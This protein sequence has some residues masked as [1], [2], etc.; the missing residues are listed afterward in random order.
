[1][2]ALLLLAALTGTAHADIKPVQS[3][4]LYAGV[5][6]TAKLAT[7]S[8]TAA[9]ILS[10]AASL[11]KVSAGAAVS[12]GGL[13]GVGT[14]SPGT[15]LHM[16]SGTLT[17]DGNVAQKA[18]FRGASTADQYVTFGH[19]DASIVGYDLGG[20]LAVGSTAGDLV[21]RDNGGIS[22]SADGGSA[23]N[24]RIDGAITTGGALCINASKNLAKCTSAVDASGNCTCP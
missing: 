21:I 16:S 14:Q 17:V 20:D 6:D 1:M 11:N 13:I 5:V 10:D 3:H 19:D 23:T 8:V 22:F 4:G 24:L 2:K 12:V 15:K 7:D 18:A 9:K